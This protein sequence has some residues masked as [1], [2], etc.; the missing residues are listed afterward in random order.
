LRAQKLPPIVENVNPSQRATFSF[1]AM[2]LL[3]LP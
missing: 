3:L 2:V 1:L